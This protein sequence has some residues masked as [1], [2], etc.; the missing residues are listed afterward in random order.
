MSAFFRAVALGAVGLSVLTLVAKEVRADCG[1]LPDH[2]QLRAALK[3]ANNA[4]D[5]TLNNEM[6]GTIVAEDGTVCAVAPGAGT[7]TVTASRTF[8][9]V[10]TCFLQSYFGLE[11]FELRASATRASAASGCSGA[12]YVLDRAKFG[13]IGVWYTAYSRLPHRLR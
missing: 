1:D 10:T 11:P 3:A 8:E 9:P 4:V 12:S 7:V 13:F 5:L 6:W 2:D